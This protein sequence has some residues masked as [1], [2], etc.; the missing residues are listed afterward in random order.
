MHIGAFFFATDYSIEV[1]ELAR[2][3]EERGFESLFLCEH[4]QLMQGWICFSA[5][6]HGTT[7]QSRLKA[8]CP[9]AL[10]SFQLA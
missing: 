10:H 9:T 4:T 8:S 6:H 7:S 3:M 5:Q 1:A 2:E